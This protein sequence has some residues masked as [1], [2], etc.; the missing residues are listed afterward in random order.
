M[1]PTRF[2]HIK[3]KVRTEHFPSK[4]LDGDVIVVPMSMSSSRSEYRYC[5]WRDEIADTITTCRLIHHSSKSHLF[6]SEC[7]VCLCSISLGSQIVT[8]RSLVV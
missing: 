4:S 3:T 8:K 1:G 7:S 5:S 6:L 2:F